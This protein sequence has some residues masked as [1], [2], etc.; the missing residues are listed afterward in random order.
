M[1]Q[2]HGWFLIS[3]GEFQK[4][5]EKMEQAVQFDPLSLPLM[6]QLGNAYAFARQFDKALAEFDKVLELDPTFRAGFEGKGMTYLAMGEYEKSIENFE[7][8]QLLIG[9]PLKGL[10]S[11]CHA[12][13]VGG[14]QQKAIECLQKIKQREATEPGA[15]LDMDY[16][17]LYSGMKDF[18]NAFHFLNNVYEKRMGVACL[19]MIFCIRYP[20]LNE[21][22]ADPRFKQLTTKIGLE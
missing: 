22:K 16:A 6:V 21:L 14:Y 7:K 18:D 9:H 19:G 5:V 11:L 17:F 4:A 10:S 8:Y 13:A 2:V 12:Y 15:I 20:M 1:N 3:K